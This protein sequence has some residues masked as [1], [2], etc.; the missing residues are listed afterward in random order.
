[1]KSNKP[2]AQ[3][4]SVGM[5]HPLP[6]NPA[7]KL[8]RKLV[9]RIEKLEFI[10]MAELLPETWASDQQ[11]T[12]DIGPQQKQIRRGPVTDILVWVECFSLLASVLAAKH[13]EKTPQLWAYQR[14][15]V[16]SCRNFDDRAWVAYDRIYS[17]Q[18]LANRSLD[19][20]V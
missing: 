1:M 17:R 15:I 16:Q 3:D 7:A 14:R 4:P 11:G 19:W 9:S 10:E 18:A 2:G 8:P 6:Y 13:P 12:R 5:L 20:S